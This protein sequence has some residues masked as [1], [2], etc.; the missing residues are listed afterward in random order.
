MFSIQDKLH[1]D[2]RH[3]AEV[4]DAQ[5]AE[6][7]NVEFLKVCQEYGLIGRE[8]DGFKDIVAGIRQKEHAH[9]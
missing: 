1:T 4:W 9:A 6:I 3:V 5:G 8:V 7:A 2:A